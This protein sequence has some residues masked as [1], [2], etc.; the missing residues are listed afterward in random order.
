[1]LK[2]PTAMAVVNS[3]SLS[4]PKPV[5][6]IA[7]APK[8]NNR[9][10]WLLANSLPKKPPSFSRT[11]TSRTANENRGNPSAAKLAP[12]KTGKPSVAEKMLAFFL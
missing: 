7:M 3:S 10:S 5:P 11:L 2:V 1:M 12:P 4:S 6:A 8:K 9:S